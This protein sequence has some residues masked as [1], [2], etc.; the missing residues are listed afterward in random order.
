[1]K[2]YSA[3]P[4]IEIPAFLQ[5]PQW[6]DESWRNDTCAK[7]VRYL[8]EDMSRLYFC[9]WVEAADPANREHAKHSRYVV[10]VV[11]DENNPDNDLYFLLKTD[12]DAEVED[13]LAQAESAFVS[14]G[15]A[16]LQS[17]VTARV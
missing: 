7:S 4:S 12:A 2:A 15:A 11:L 13:L 17:F 6:F 5:G 9:V 10:Q 3:F 14:G 8:T 1:M 16:S